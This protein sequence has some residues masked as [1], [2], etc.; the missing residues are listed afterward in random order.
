[1]LSKRRVLALCGCLLVVAEAG[2]AT[3]IVNGQN[4]VAS[5]ANPGTSVEPLKTISAAAARAKAGDHVIIHG[6]DYRETVIIT[7]SGTA[8]DPII[9]EAAPGERPV[10]KGSD[11][12]QGW[13]KDEG[14]VWKVKLPPLPPHGEDGKDP[15]FWNTNDVRQIFTKDGT[16]LDAQRLRRV[17]ER[18]AMEAGTFFCDTNAPLLFVWLSDSES[19]NEHPPEVAVRGAWLY[20]YGSNVTIRGLQ[21]RHAST[22]ALAN[23]PACGLEG[24][25]NALEDCLVSWGDFA[26]V[27]LAGRGHRLQRNV[28]ACHGACGVG[29]RGENHVIENCRVVYNNVDRYNTDWHA[30]GA[31][32]I[33]NFH[34]GTIRHNEF[35]HNLGPGLWLDNQCDENVIDGNFSHDNEGAGIMVEVSTGNLVMNNISVANRNLLS[36]SYRTEEGKEIEIPYS[37]QRIAPSRLFK[38]Y[39]AGDG[40]GIYISTSPRTKVL[41]NTVYLNEGEGICVEGPKR[42]EG[43]TALATQDFVVLN[44]ISVFNKGSQLTIRPNETSKENPGAVSDYNLLFSV[45]AVLGRNGWDS[46]STFELKEWQKISGQDPHSIDADPRFAMAVMNDFRLMRNSPTLHAGKPLPEVDHDYFGQ[47][48]RREKTAIGACETAAENYPSPL[49]DETFPRESQ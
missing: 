15:A 8:K 30:G 34:H 1:M 19:P 26:G 38:P 35:A 33:P 10:I 41:N 36:G 24:D 5:D 21:M 46:G 45:G 31:K 7:T 17:K 22:T 42:G 20:L 29:G 14:A 44:N 11:I 28:I 49:W 3:L 32:L 43:A 2:A 23:W 48:R 4:P 39:H 37:E 25:N 47:P 9:F 13:Q 6:G 12:L 18:K 27:S 40:R 16:M